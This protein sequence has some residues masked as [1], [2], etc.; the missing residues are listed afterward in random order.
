MKLGSA[1]SDLLLMLFNYLEAKQDLSSICMAID[2]HVNS[3]NYKRAISL[4]DKYSK[5]ISN[6]EFNYLSS[7]IEIA[8]DMQDD[9]DSSRETNKH[10]GLIT[11]ND[12]K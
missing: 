10:Y 1:D 11:S 5:Q 3:R 2:L 7:M 12:I 4:Y 9:T 6:S 8:K